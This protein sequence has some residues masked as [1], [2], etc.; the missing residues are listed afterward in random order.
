MTVQA[1]VD[2][3]GSHSGSPV[4]ILGGFVADHKQWAVFAHEWQ[5]ALDIKPKLDYFKMSEA[6]SLH[7]Q[8]HP[9][10]G[11]DET[12]R[13]ER[14]EILANVIAKYAKLK[15]HALMR[16]DDFNELIRSLPAPRRS[17]SI[18]G[19]F[20][21]LANQLILAVAISADL[22][23]ISDPCDFIFDETDG[24]SEEF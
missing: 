2:D 23:G 5:A 19:P 17:L 3:S 13:D 6:A 4:F 8:F 16:H 15:I 21:I 1:F 9:T 18:D 7:G 12:K 11:W 24:F 20:C 14:L 22:Y 10:K